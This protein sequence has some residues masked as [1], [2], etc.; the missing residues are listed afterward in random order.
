MIKFAGRIT[1]PLNDGEI[2]R[3]IALVIIDAEEGEMSMFYKN[4][5]LNLSL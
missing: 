1:D 4:K 2:I 3:V 5:F